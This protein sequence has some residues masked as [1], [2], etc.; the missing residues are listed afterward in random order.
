MNGPPKDLISEYIEPTDLHEAPMKKQKRPFA[1]GDKIRF[2][3]E[4]NITPSI[5]IIDQHYGH[6]MDVKIDH[7]KN[8]PFGVYRIVRVTP[9]QIISRIIKKPK[10]VPREFWIHIPEDNSTQS[11]VTGKPLAISKDTKEVIHVKEVFPK[12]KK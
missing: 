8:S 7:P 11:F 6:V 12:E 10:R 5:G 4:A 9:R 1:V 3:N 2:E